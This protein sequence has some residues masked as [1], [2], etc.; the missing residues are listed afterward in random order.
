MLKRAGLLRSKLPLRIGFLCLAAFIG[1]HFTRRTTYIS[2]P[3]PLRDSLSIK[4][5][6]RYR[7]TPGFNVPF[8]FLASLAL[9]DN[10]VPK[11]YENADHLKNKTFLFIFSQGTYRKTLSPNNSFELD[12]ISC[13]VGKMK[14]PIFFNSYGLQICRITY[15]PNTNDLITLEASKSIFKVAP[16]SRTLYSDLQDLLGRRNFL[17]DSNAFWTE[18]YDILDTKQQTKYE[19]CAMTQEKL[20]PELLKPWI[21]YHSKLGVD[22]FYI[23]DN[24]C[25]KNLKQLLDKEKNVEVID[26]PWNRSQIQ[27]QNHFLLHSRRRCHWIALFDVDEYIVIRRDGK[28]S[29][30][31]SRTYN[32]LRHIVRGFK[33]NNVSS[34][35][36]D[37]ITMGSSGR[38][39]TPKQPPPEAYT[40]MVPETET[41]LPKSIVY[42]EHIFPV[43][44]VHTITEYVGYRRSSSSLCLDTFSEKDSIGIIHYR[45]RSW[46]EFI[47]KR[48][49]KN[50][51]QVEEPLSSEAYDIKKP[52]ARHL[53]ISNQE[54]FLEFRAIFQFVKDLPENNAVLVSPDETAY[55]NF[56]KL[57]EIE[58][59]TK[60]NIENKYTTK[61]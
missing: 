6:N 2:K 37:S 51:Y 55:D 60:L 10:L 52:H 4:Y 47:R 34:M 61:F 45:L 5:L 30:S 44:H 19:I 18:Q 28:W 36:V 16:Q 58:K 12:I 14:Y 26:W 41:A 29:E 13:V 8:V 56:L 50:S 9:G 53:D 1:V 15:K 54:Q 42:A 38:V 33:V 23:Y 24:L 3:S 25:E 17:L 31:A 32:S 49:S 11:S 57:P 48:T 7:T 40:H 59:S 22:R 27:A 43:S 20:F 21:S 35:I 39:K 46:E